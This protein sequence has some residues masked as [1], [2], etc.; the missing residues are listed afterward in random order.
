MSFTKALKNKIT[1]KVSD[2]LS[3]PARKYYE[4]RSRGYDRKYNAMKD[5]QSKAKN[6]VATDKDRAVFNMLKGK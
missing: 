1:G 3:A 6:R 4:S 2:V 5:Y